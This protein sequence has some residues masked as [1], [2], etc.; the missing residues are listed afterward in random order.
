MKPTTADIEEA[1]QS[2]GSI[3]EAALK[4]EPITVW[5]RRFVP[6]EANTETADLEAEIAEMRDHLKAHG[7]KFF[8]DRS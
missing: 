8:K 5:G 2:L 1:V 4:G 6:S 7:C 3:K